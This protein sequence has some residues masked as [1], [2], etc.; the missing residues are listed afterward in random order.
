M[1]FVNVFSKSCKI[2]AGATENG[3]GENRELRSAGYIPDCSPRPPRGVVLERAV[4][5]GPS[6]A[7]RACSTCCSSCVSSCWK[8]STPDLAA[9][10]SNWKRTN[11]CC[12]IRI[13]KNGGKVRTLLKKEVRI[14]PW[15]RN[16]LTPPRTP[17]VHQEKSTTPYFIFCTNLK[18]IF[19]S[20]LMCIFYQ[21]II[22]N[23]KNSN[24]AITLSFLGQKGKNDC[25]FL[26]SNIVFLFSNSS[27]YISNDGIIINDFSFSTWKFFFELGGE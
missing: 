25:S 11:L 26:A 8:A 27:T 2:G 17:R 20:M 5:P 13:F 9:E 16:S 14:L 7:S 24:P 19:A 4:T 21:K 6:R 18:V 12:S 3:R 22:E 15:M 23:R 10:F 1:I